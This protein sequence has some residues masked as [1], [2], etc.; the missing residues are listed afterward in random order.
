MTF[1]VRLEKADGTPADPPTSG[2]PSG[3]EFAP[4]VAARW[5][6]SRSGNERA[7]R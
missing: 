7:S 6:G 1:T 5:R 3:R 2:A 4:A